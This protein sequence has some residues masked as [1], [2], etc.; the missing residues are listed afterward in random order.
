VWL[1]NGYVD[2]VFVG[3]TSSGLLRVATE[4]GEMVFAAGEVQ[5]RP[6]D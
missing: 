1:H 2:G 3:I 4:S 5:L 6:L